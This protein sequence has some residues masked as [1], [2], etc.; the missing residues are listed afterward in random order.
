MGPMEQIGHQDYRLVCEKLFEDMGKLIDEGLFSP[1]LVALLMQ[2][3]CSFIP[4]EIVAEKTDKTPSDVPLYDH[5]RLTAAF[6]A[7]IYRSIDEQYHIVY[8][9]L[10]GIQK[11]VYTISSRGALK[12]LRARSFFLELLT[13]HIVQRIVEGCEVSPLNV[14]YATGGIFS[15]LIPATE[16]TTDKINDIRESVNDYLA[17]LHDGRVYLAMEYGQEPFR[18]ADFITDDSRNDILGKEKNIKTSINI[19]KRQRFIEKIGSGGYE[20]YIGPFSPECTKPHRNLEKVNTD[21]CV[22]CSKSTVEPSSLKFQ[23]KGRLRDI[24]YQIFGCEKCLADDKWQ[25]GAGSPKSGECSVCHKESSLLI[26]LPEPSLHSGEKEPVSACIFCN[27]LYHLGEHLPMGSS[28]VIVRKKEKPEYEESKAFVFIEDY[29]YYLKKNP[30]KTDL[31]GYI[32]GLNELDPLNL[33]KLC[34]SPDGERINTFMMSRHQPWKQGK[35][36][37]YRIMPLD[38]EELAEKSTGADKLGV[39]KMD[40]DNLGDI[41]TKGLK[42]DKNNTKEIIPLARRLA[43]SRQME[44]FFKLYIDEICKGNYGKPFDKPYTEFS[45]FKPVSNTESS[46]GSERKSEGR[47]V[48]IVYSG[49]DDLF[50]VGAWNDVTEMAFDVHRSFKA[51]TAE[52][53]SV[54]VSGGLVLT[55]KSYPL[56]HMA[57][58]AG[59]A[60]KKAKDYEE[61][62]FKKASLTMFYV[63]QGR[64]YQNKSEIPVALRWQKPNESFGLPTTEDVLGLVKYFSMFG[65]TYEGANYKLWKLK[66]SRGFIQD[67]FQIVDLYQRSG[68][69]YLPRLVYIGSEPR[70]SPGSR[71]DRDEWG[72]FIDKLRCLDTIKYLSFALTWVDLLC[73]SKK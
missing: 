47:N 26:N 17:N 68:K 36:T 67:L 41:F 18:D 37:S 5:L 28:S 32:W 72:K 16:G 55:S 12:T 66:I 10:S 1:N 46:Q 64:F 25:D 60:L 39:L 38:F 29:Y 13:L 19:A 27:L 15:V 6:G 59:K 22:R 34:N 44:I 58:L 50:M 23:D 3:Y 54:D 56:Y 51:Y 65:E 48:V 69:L 14:L 31:N 21:D 61:K 45:D 62:G 24:D 52:N 35:E 33:A 43:L 30:E 11:F 71:I 63:P 42:R 70:S 2:K 7:C 49:G 53:P 9:D 20:S 73:R 8:G 57:D 4:H 40:V